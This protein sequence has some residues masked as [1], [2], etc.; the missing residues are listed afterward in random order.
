MGQE[1]VSQLTASGSYTP[2]Q[3]ALS[4]LVAMLPLGSSFIPGAQELGSYSFSRVHLIM[5]SGDRYRKMSLAYSSS[6][7]SSSRV[8]RTKKIS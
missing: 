4:A 5:V 7:S 6:S 8:S 2:L 3:G 1:D